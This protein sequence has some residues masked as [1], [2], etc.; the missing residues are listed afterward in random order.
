MTNNEN[1][2]MVNVMSKIAEDVA[3]SAWEKVKKFFKDISAQDAIRYGTAYEEYLKN[4]KNKY[5]KI[6]TLI[7]R[8]SPRDIYSFYE[9]IGLRYK[10]K[11]IDTSTVLNLIDLSS[12]II[13]TGTGGIG[14]SM[15]MKH[16]FLN[17]IESMGLIPI[18]IELRSFNTYD[19]KEISLKKAIY[20]T[21]IEFGFSLEEEYFEE[22]V[23]EGGYLILLD[24]YD[25]VSRDKAQIITRE[26]REF[27]NKYPENKFIISSRPSDEFIGWNDFAE[28]RSLKLTK[29]QALNLIK[30]I[31]FDA[32]TKEV[33]YKQLDDKLYEKYE[34]FASNPLLLT[35][36][37][38]TF[39]DNAY[40]PDTLNDFY[41][42]AFSTLFNMHDATKEAYVRDIRSGLGCEDFKSV[43]SYICFKSYFKNQYD[44]TEYEIRDYI[45]ACQEKFPN[46]SISVD[47]YLEDLTLSVCML[48]KDGLKYSFTHRSFQEYFA[49]LYTCKLVDSDQTKLL[50]SWLK[51]SSNARIDM[52]FNMYFNMQNEKVNKIILLPG[53]KIIDEHYKKYGFSI[54]FLRKIFEEKISVKS[55]KDGKF[56]ITLYVGDIYLCNV[57][58]L[59]YMLNGYRGFL[60]GSEEHENEFAYQVYK[61][62]KDAKEISY[63]EIIRKYGEEAFLNALKEFESEFLFCIDI[64]KKYSTNTVGNKRKVS[65]IIDEL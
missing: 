33:F 57:F 61:D 11:D 10:G 15:L 2:L 20:D 54:E 47:N 13:V 65:S 62:F 63:E 9:C 39:S 42:Q 27:S 52:Y 6:K 44:F 41:E 64:L 48:V 56:Y 35:I 50:T 4:A 38:L 25:E 19:T 34:S 45:K 14:K 16:L 53:L 23:K 58:V 49:A 12:K 37:L 60:K 1:E 43:F 5:S 21:L 30:K 18:F 26:I 29:Q 59:T 55:N 36:M 24:G 7:Y 51:E 17:S 28:M 32:K 31:D 8:H 3:L 22:S 46:L 40:M